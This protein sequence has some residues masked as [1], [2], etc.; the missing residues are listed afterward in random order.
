MKKLALA[1]VAFAGVTALGAGNSFASP[2]FIAYNDAGSTPNGH[3][4]SST[5]HTFWPATG[6]ESGGTGGTAHYT[7]T[8]TGS[9]HIKGTASFGSFSASADPTISFFHE[10][11]SGRGFPAGANV[12]R[13][14]T[15]RLDS[16]ATITLFFAQGLSAFGLDLSPIA[17]DW[18]GDIAAFGASNHLLGTASVTGA[19]ICNGQTNC[20]VQF[21]GV[22][23]SVT[24]I[25]KIEVSLSG[26]TFG[27]IQI[28]PLDEKLAVSRIPEPASLSVLGAGLLA[29]GA[30]RRRRLHDPEDGSRWS[31]FGRW[32]VTGRPP[33]R[34][35]PPR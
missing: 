8:S 4:F 32:R 7:F 2:G 16:T 33:D 35:H 15:P 18:G 26:S 5:D 24:P 27:P 34:K 20:P 12:M 22:S 10:A 21:L 23:D 13:T 29:L 28:G 17:S 11:S 31:P 3:T 1:S 9:H 30:L 19:A 6:S 25:T 14:N